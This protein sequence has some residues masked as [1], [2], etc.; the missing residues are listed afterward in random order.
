VVL[1]PFYEA[2]LFLIQYNV[3]TVPLHSS[4]VLP[5]TSSIQIYSFCFSLERNRFQRDTNKTYQKINKMKQ[6][7]PHP[8][9]TKQANRKIK[10]PQEKAQESETRRF[11]Q[12][13]VP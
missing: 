11:T 9:W 2:D 12:S 6:E 4:Q 13:G 3:I 5:A 8:G 10:E 1:P 7:P